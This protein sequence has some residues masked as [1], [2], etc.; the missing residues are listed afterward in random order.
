MV[1][2]RKRPV[3][4]TVLQVTEFGFGSATLAGMNG[5]VVSPDQARATVTAALDAGVGYFDTAPHY[6]FGR[7]EQQTIADSHH[8]DGG[9]VI[10]DPSA[11]VTVHPRRVARLERAAV[12][13]VHWSVAQA[14]PVIRTGRLQFAGVVAAV[15]FDLLLACADGQIPAKVSHAMA[16]CIVDGDADVAGLWHRERHIR[17]TGGVVRG[18][19]GRSEAGE[20]DESC[21]MSHPQHLV[22]QKD[23]RGA[24]LIIAEGGAMKNGV[25]G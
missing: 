17:V 12:N 1:E 19:R 7:A 22:G 4:R 6:G 20:P 23:Y 9:A 2:F 16:C 8:G 24:P 15:P 25:R 18:R 13:R 5:T 10:G 21:Q 11:G 14:D 3:G